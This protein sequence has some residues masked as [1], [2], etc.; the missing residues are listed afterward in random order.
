MFIGLGSNL[1]NR[2]EHLRWVCRQLRAHA[3]IELVAV[4][5]VYTSAA[6]TLDGSAQPAYLNAVVKLSTALDAEKLLLVLHAYEREAGRDRG[7]EGRW[8][9]RTLDLDILAY[10]NAQIQTSGLTIPHRRL[11]DRRF[12]LQPWH[13][14]A[15]G[16]LVPVPFDQTVAELL[17]GCD[18]RTELAKTSWQL[19]D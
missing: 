12:V 16:F 13:D 19:L 11:A 10:G 4:S 2:I 15:S 6:H 7:K 17:A 14:V 1:G 18:D 5:P 9:S 3:A 8:G